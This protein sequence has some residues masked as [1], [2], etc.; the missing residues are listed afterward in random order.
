MAYVF[1]K[2]GKAATAFD[3]KTG[4]IVAEFPLGGTPQA[5]VVDAKRGKVYVNLQD[6]NAIAVIDT[7]SKKLTTTWSIEPGQNQS[8][9][10]I[11]LEHQR[12]FVGC[13][14]KLMV[15]LDATN[16]KVLAQVPI[17][18][19]TD[20][21]WFDPGHQARVQFH[22]RRH[23]HGCARGFTQHDDDRPN[24]GDEAVRADDDG[25]SQDA[26]HLSRCLR[27]RGADS[28]PDR[29][30]RRSFRERFARSSTRWL[31]EGCM[32]SRKGGLTPRGL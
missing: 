15:M 12:L 30:G 23:G 7:A 1:A 13:R 8:G 6:K 31:D 19:G 26:S 5:T 29:E 4:A 27:L 11:D 10:A 24:A 14:N 3:A 32:V 28:R 17:G 25:R 9:L 2:A 16:G 18:S 20:S 21:S 22:G